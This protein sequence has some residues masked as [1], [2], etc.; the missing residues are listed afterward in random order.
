MT[1]S[2][3][4]PESFGLDADQ[5]DGMFVP[6]AYQDSLAA[7]RSQSE[8]A[9]A[10]ANTN[11]WRLAT[12]LSLGIAAFAVVGWRIAD[13][14]FANNVRVA[15]VKLS[16]DGASQVQYFDDGGAAN[17][18]FQATVNASLINYIEHR[19]RQ[20]KETI[21]ADYGYALNFMGEPVRTE[22]LQG[23]NAPKVAAEL[24]ACPSCDQVDVSVRAVDHDTMVT[25]DGKNAETAVYESTVY[26]TEQLFTSGGTATPHNKIVKLVWSLRKVAELTKNLA[27]LKVNPLGIQIIGERELDDLAPEANRK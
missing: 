19:Y 1:V 14:R 23:F 6:S 25:P 20:R 9:R 15:W 3:P 22:F 18:F 27:M 2:H 26:L 5:H 16:P 13:D 8:L 7:K 24:E 4:K 11:F 12:V 21:S 17:R 10:Y